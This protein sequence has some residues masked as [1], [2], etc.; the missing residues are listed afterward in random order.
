MHLTGKFHNRYG[1]VVQMLESIC[2]HT[3]GV[4]LVSMLSQ[5]LTN[6]RKHVK[7]T[8]KL[9]RSQLLLSNCVSDLN[10]R[11]KV[12]D[13]HQWALK[14]AANS[15]YGS[16]AFKEYNIYSPRC[17]VI[18]RWSLHMSIAIATQ[19]G[20]CVVYCHA[21]VKTRRS[22]TGSTSLAKQLLLIVKAMDANGH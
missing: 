17:G 4:N 20:T 5:H 2:K 11:I 9:L 21:P 22:S 8:M 15:L 19:L 16:F 13:L 7:K 18:G 6:E 12:C 1:S 3:L 14:I 10:D